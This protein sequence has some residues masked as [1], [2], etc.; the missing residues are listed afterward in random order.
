MDNEHLRFG[1]DGKLAGLYALNLDNLTGD[2]WTKIDQIIHEYARI[3]PNEMKL[4]VIENKIISSNRINETA[5]NKS[6][7]IRWGASIPVALMFKLQLAVPE[8][9][10][11]KAIFHQFLKKYKGFAICKKI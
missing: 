10:E 4:L 5:S 9:L 2:I 3:H 6:K 8:L 1:K 7:S 11:N